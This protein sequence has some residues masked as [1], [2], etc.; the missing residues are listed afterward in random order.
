MR[1]SFRP[2]VA[3]KRL[4]SSQVSAVSFRTNSGVKA[5]EVFE[6][7]AVEE[8]G[9]ILWLVHAPEHSPCC[10]HRCG[11]GLQGDFCFPS[12]VVAARVRPVPPLGTDARPTGRARPRNSGKFW[13]HFVIQTSRF[14][15]PREDFSGHGSNT[16]QTR[17]FS[18]FASRPKL[19]VDV[20]GIYPCF[21]RG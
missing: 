10:Y 3:G 18:N 9:L 6:R 12:G 8:D 17:I 16:D 5:G 13:G 4:N 7:E 19:I 11:S 15:A 20:Q 14:F 21:I 2:G 1:L